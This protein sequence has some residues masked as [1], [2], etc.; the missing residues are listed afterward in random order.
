M[1]SASHTTTSTPSRLRLLPD[2]GLV[3]LTDPGLPEGLAGQVSDQLE[4][5]RVEDG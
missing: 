3:D 5:V 1:K 4:A 2:V